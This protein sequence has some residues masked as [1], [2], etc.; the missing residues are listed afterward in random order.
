VSPA[1]PPWRSCRRRRRRPRHD[2]PNG[3]YPFKLGVASGDPTATGVVLWTR[4]APQPFEPG[5]GMPAR[6][7]TVQWQ[8][9]SD[10]RF[11][12]VVRDGQPGAQVV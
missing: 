7:A 3:E 4:L 5:G 9:A 6:R 8:V 1:P 10:E 12:R 2:R 11:R